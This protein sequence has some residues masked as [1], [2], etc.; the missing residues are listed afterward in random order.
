MVA[1]KN[2]TDLG[3]WGLICCHH[4]PRT[5]G[6][7]DEAYNAKLQQG[8]WVVYG[9]RAMRYFLAREEPYGPRAIGSCMW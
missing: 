4:G 7:K 6:G 3:Q 5:I 9:T 2:P 1:W 8:H